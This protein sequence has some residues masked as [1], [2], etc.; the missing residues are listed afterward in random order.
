MSQRHGRAAG[1]SAASRR[2]RN[3][4]S[5]WILVAVV[6]ASGCFGTGEYL[7]DGLQSCAGCGA[8]VG[9]LEHRVVLIGDAGEYESDTDNLKALSRVARQAPERTV[10]VFL[11]D[12]VYPRGVPA[13]PE[14]ETVADLPLAMGEERDSAEEKLR[15]QI[16]AVERAGAQ[17]IFLPG[18]HDWDR[19]G[20][21]GL[22]RI[23]AQGDFIATAAE[24]PT[25][26]RM[27]P[28]DGCPG[29]VFMD[30]GESLRLILVDT[31]WLLRRDRERTETGCTWGSEADGQAM[32]PAG[33]NAVFEALLAAVEGAGDRHVLFATHHPFKSRGPHG[34]YFTVQEFFFPFTL[35]NEKLYIPLPILYP[36]VRYWVVRSDEDLIGSENELVRRRLEAILSEAANLPTI[37]AA[38]HEHSM[39]VFDDPRYPILYLVSGAGSK[40][41]PVGTTDDTLFKDRDIGFMVVDYFLDGRVSVRVLEPDGE[42]NHEVSFG[43]WADERRS[44]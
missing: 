19:N 18:N 23:L 4:A 9:E 31:V 10:V 2:A 5:S 41:T 38:G 28:G 8:A 6:A 42:D 13:V 33:N 26:V 37:A 30:L 15:A 35:L 21:D 11:G 44:R 17:G 22:A 14:G 1:G 29:P 7:R 34:G 3:L 40:T 16:H 39:Q 36:V 43:M 12:N 27:L 32:E 20:D 25:R 24:D